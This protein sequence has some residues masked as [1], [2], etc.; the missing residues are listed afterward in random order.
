MQEM[1]VGASG[2]E[3]TRRR[4]PIP[5]GP[6]RPLCGR[7][8]S[9]LGR[10][11]RSACPRTVSPLIWPACSRECRTSRPVARSPRKSAGARV[12]IDLSGGGTRHRTHGIS[13]PHIF[14]NCVRQAGRARDRPVHESWSVSVHDVPGPRVTRG[15]RWR[16]SSTT[17]GAVLRRSGPQAVSG[18]GG[19]TVAGR[20]G[21]RGRPRCW[22]RARRASRCPRIRDGASRMPRLAWPLRPQ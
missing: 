12:P 3:G 16:T 17:R 4:D 7:P 20:F 10:C 1:G 2:T 6:P 13:R 11:S 14:P 22:R 8:P 9:S 15:M 18:A 5:V 19:G 21:C